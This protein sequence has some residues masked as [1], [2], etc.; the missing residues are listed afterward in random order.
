MGVRGGDSYVSGLRAHPKSVWIAGRKVADV[1][2]DPALRR[3]V[4]AMAA[5]YDCQ[6]DDELRAKM[7]YR[8]DDADDEAG[9]SFIVPRTPDDLVRR[10]EA[11]RVW[12]DATF[13]FM[14]RSPDYLNTLLAS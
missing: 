7:T 12:A 1:T 3:P 2:Q 10:R 9:L 14:G 6:V 4:A 11:M 5:L 8:P 13:G